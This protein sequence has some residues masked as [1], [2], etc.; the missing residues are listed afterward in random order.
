[1]HEQL[2]RW[3]NAG[4]MTLDEAYE[5]DRMLELLVELVKSGVVDNEQAARIIALMADAQA[6]LALSPSSQGVA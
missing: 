3:V 2:Q 1:M 4:L 6:D 5:H